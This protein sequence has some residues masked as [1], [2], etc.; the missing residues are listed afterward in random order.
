MP[1]DDLLPLVN[2]R[3]GHFAYESGHHSDLWLDLE[4]LCE[5]PT[6]LRTRNIQRL[7]SGAI[8]DPET[9]AQRRGEHSSRNRQ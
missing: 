1:Y 3:S 5:S 7:I 8:P 4:T 9:F 6:A 2:A